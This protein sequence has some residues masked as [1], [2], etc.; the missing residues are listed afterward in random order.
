MFFQQLIR[1]NI[2]ENIEDLQF[3][4]FVEGSLAM[5]CY[6]EKVAIAAFQK[7]IRVWRF[8]RGVTV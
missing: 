7:M 5:A 1:V 3:K 2:K 6:A 8:R 4:L